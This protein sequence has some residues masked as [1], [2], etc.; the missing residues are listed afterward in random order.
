M[1]LPVLNQKGEKVKDLALPKIFDIEFSPKLITLYVNYLRAALRSPIAST[2]DRSEVR[3]GGRKPWRQKGTGNARVGS[4]RSPLWIHGGTTF[5][6]TP[7]RN[8]HLRLN[9]KI[10]RKAILSFFAEAARNK[11]LV[12]VDDFVLAA[13]KTKEGAK[14]LSILGAAGKTSVILTLENENIWLSLRNI[15]GVKLMAPGRLDYLHLISSDKII[16]TRK[17]MEEMGKIYE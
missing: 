17:A 10:R 4:I 13:P 6:P 3:G 11:S 9:K 14:T 12:I 2:L 8:F 1:K 7:E 5:G 15:A 16:I